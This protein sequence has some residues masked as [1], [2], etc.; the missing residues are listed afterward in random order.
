MPAFTEN[1]VIGRQTPRGVACDNLD[2]AVFYADLSVSVG[3]G[4]INHWRVWLAGESPVMYVVLNQEAPG[5][6]LSDVGIWIDYN[7]D[8]VPDGW[9]EGVKPLSAVYPSICDFVKAYLR[10][11]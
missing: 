4:S 11:M 3:D 10:G 9:Y 7:G 5:S 1:Q 2:I 8:G 6:P